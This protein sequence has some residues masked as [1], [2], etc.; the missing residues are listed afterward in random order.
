MNFTLTGARKVINK[1]IL[2]V[3]ILIAV[4]LILAY[5]FSTLQTNTQKSRPLLSKEQPVT[6]GKFDTQAPIS[7]KSKASL[8]KLKNNLPYRSTVNLTTG[9]TVAFV[10]SA[11]PADLYALYIEIP[12]LNF[13]S[14]YADTNLPK[15]VDEFRE[16]A[17]SI[18]AWIKN[19]EVSPNNIFISWGS[20]AYIQQNAEK[21]LNPSP[22]FP[23]VIKQN[24]KYVFEKEPLKT[25]N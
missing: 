9:R 11:K 18:L 1:K 24:D 7:Q 8:D 23:K 10:I 15:N 4:V 14:D 25:P 20:K 19:Q 16:T 6:N 17:S 21:W 3:L 2:I 5:V 13:R 12:D 22:Q